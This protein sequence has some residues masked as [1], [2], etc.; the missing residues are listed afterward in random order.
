MG[1]RDCDGY[2]KEWES[3][4]PVCRDCSD[5]YTCR[6]RTLKRERLHEKRRPKIDRSDT[7]TS[8]RSNHS[9]YSYPTNTKYLLPEDGERAIF[10][11]I[12]NMLAGGLSAM[13]G[14]IFVFFREWRW[15]FT[16]PS[17]T[18][19]IEAPRPQPTPVEKPQSAKSSKRIAVEDFDDELNIDLD[20]L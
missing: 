12:K 15:P 5:E 8:G 3:G 11:I 7:T 2:G 9:I 6:D 19:P 13:G 17:R 16:K 14:E 18:K 20:D 4:D 10:R 1:S